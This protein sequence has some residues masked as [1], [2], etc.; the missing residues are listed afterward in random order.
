M[1]KILSSEK[2]FI[3]L[4]LSEID[5][6]KSVFFLSFSKRKK[7]QLSV[8]K[9]H[10]AKPSQKKRKRMKTYQGK[11][12]RKKTPHTHTQ[13]NFTPRCT[14]YFSVESKCLLFLFF[15]IGFFRPF[16]FSFRH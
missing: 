2:K 8:P 4:G 14:I 10:D 7:K 6:T 13:I 3:L 11:K 1:I 5:K 15:R 16:F 12:E 9:I